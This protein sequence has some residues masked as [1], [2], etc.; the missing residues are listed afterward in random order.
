MAGPEQDIAP[1]AEADFRAELDEAGIAAAP[2]LVARAHAIAA[3]LDKGLAALPD[4]AAGFTTVED[5]AEFSIPE[6]GARLR[7]GRLTAVALTEAVLARI[8][9]FQP[10]DRSFILVMAEAAL[11]AAAV[12]DAELA[13]GHDR[14]PLHGIPI[15]IKDM[16]DVV[17]TPTTA[18]SKGRLQTIAETDAALVARLRE[19]GAIIIGKLATYEWATVG[20]SFDGPF[21]PAT[22]PWNPAHI[23]GGSSSGSASAVAGRILRTAIG[24]DTGG[25]IRAPANYCG[26]IG[27]KP[28]FGLV[29]MA[30]VLPLSPSLDHAG[31]L[32][33]TV[34]EAALT[35]DALAGLSGAESAAREI[36]QGV[37]GLKLAYARDF[38]AADPQVSPAVIE[39]MDRAVSVL[40]GLG[41]NVTLVTLPDYFEAEIAA[42][43]ILHAESFAWHRGGLAAEPE[44]YGR[45]T[46]ESL[47]AGGA[48]TEAQVEKARAYGM[49]LRRRYDA[50]IF[51]AFDALVTAG[52]L[53]P[54]L[55]V[56]PFRTGGVWTPMRTIP[57]NLTGHPALALPIGFDGGL[58]LGMQIIGA[59]GAEA[60]I[61]RIGAAHESATDHALA[62][63]P[64][65]HR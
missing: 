50:E 14:G 65:P 57:F 32:S 63:P 33:A 59:H 46:F 60:M 41:A 53:T 16:I 30:G 21:P 10:C 28:T 3:W 47:I 6:A 15:G 45:K 7:D 25:S 36:G 20:P 1:I 40:S 64:R 13:E 49:A 29:P 8:E 54:G 48:L 61:C 23:T 12:A 4:A 26:V 35:L 22:N 5:P 62:A 51:G 42:A 56:E 2:D 17:G 27:L 34:M 11:D 37:E 44:S 18:G 31:P 38:F 39:A 43:A 58:P 9:R 24:T 19:A 55:P 52:T